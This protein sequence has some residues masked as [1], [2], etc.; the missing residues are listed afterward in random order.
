M[1]T[2][3]VCYHRATR[4]TQLQKGA[5]L[6]IILPLAFYPHCQEVLGI[7]L[8]LPSSTHNLRAS[9]LYLLGVL[10]VP[11]MPIYVRHQRAPRLPGGL[12]SLTLQFPLSSMCCY[13]VIFPYPSPAPQILPW[14]PLEFQFQQK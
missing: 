12:S 6:M 1:D 4:G 7:H 9:V 2:S 10:I 3:R 11:F 5:F 14:C 13:S 8:F